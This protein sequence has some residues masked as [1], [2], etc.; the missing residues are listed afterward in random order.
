MKFKSILGLL[1]LYGLYA[2]AQD[3]FE[4]RVKFG[5]KA[6]IN[7]SL[8]TST[9]DPFG[10]F[11]RNRLN[12]FSRFFRTS[13]FG[14][15]T[16]D[17]AVSR[18]LGIG[19][20]LLF[21]SRGMAYRERN[22]DVVILD[23]YGNEEQAYNDFNY[24]IDYVEVP[25]TI[26]YSFNAA[27]SNVWIAGYAGMAPGFVVNSITKLRYETPEYGGRRRERNEK[28]PLNNVNNFNNSLLLGIKVGENKTRGTTLF[29]DFRA[30]YAMRPVFSGSMADSGNNLDT[31]M[32]TFSVSLGL[33]F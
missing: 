23:E 17:G 4:K 18:R 25:I 19:A 2:H 27:S 14:G 21:N 31:R 8:F 7:G 33:K 24:N 15:L 3:P 29:G 10:P 28:N 30:S 12:D 1:L 26:N 13:A 32:L 6:G 5:V 22:Y 9:V 11:Q 16:A 20:E